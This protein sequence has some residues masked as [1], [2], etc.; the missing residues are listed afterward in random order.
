MV[1]A[2]LSIQF[3]GSRLSIFRKPNFD[4]RRF[5]GLR[6][7]DSGGDY[8]RVL[9]FATQSTQT[10]Y[11]QEAHKQSTEANATPLLLSDVKRLVSLL[12]QALE[13]CVGKQQLLQQDLARCRS[14]LGNWNLQ[15]P[16]SPTVKD[17]SSDQQ[18]REPTVEELEELTLLNKALEKA[19]KIRTKFL[20]HVPL[21]EAP[22][23]TRALEKKPVAHVAVKQQGTNC[24]G[25]VSK[26]QAKVTPGG[27]KP[28]SSRKPSAYVLKAP[29]QTDPEVKRLRGK[30]PAR[31]THKVPKGSGRKSL[32]GA[33]SHKAKVPI[34]ITRVECGKISVVETPGSPPDLSD[35]AQDVEQSSLL[36][37]STTGG[38]SASTGTCVS[39]ESAP[40]MCPEPQTST[41]QEKGSSLKLPLPYRKASFRLARL[42]EDCRLCQTSPEAAA[43]R[44]RFMEKLQATFSSPSPSLSLAEVEKELTSLRGVC[45]RL[46][47]CVEAETPASLGEDPAWEREYESLLALE[48][49]QPLVSQCLDKAQMLQEAVESHMRLIPACSAGSETSSSAKGPFL[50]RRRSC[51]T[52]TFGPPPLLHYSSLK[53][54]LEMESL[55]LQVAML[56][57]QID[58][59]KALEGELLPLLKPGPA[60]R[61]SRAS[62]Y[63]AIYTLLCEGG[64]HFPALV[65][66]EGLSGDLEP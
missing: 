60:P 10:L 44:D 51:C 30:T 28:A 39:G 53:E 38:S 24:K 31:L 65:C 19:V 62:L 47:Q 33:A 22:G 61:G 35:S 43:V 17:C 41:L 5:D 63:R 48:G 37:N 11:R 56:S 4:G 1:S 8:L 54:L 34:K 46:S 57:Q 49:L 29:Y 12:T 14:V 18:E 66:E 58:I 21:H 50:Q 45:A 3:S 64:T 23:G 7:S 55:R 36:G 52:E 59:Q 6:Q 26:E 42:W 25:S 20:S 2:L 9:A 13:E 27:Q 40:G 15:T 32:Q 16:D